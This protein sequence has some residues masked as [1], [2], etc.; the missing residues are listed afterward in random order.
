MHAVEAEVEKVLG[1][2]CR[3]PALPAGRLVGAGESTVPVSGSLR[4]GER[5]IT[6][7]M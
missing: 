6:G 7:G 5:A 3:A 2:F 1:F 4:M